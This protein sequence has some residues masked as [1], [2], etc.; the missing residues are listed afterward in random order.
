[1]GFVGHLPER[2]RDLPLEPPAEALRGPQ[3]QGVVPGTSARCSEVNR[4]PVGISSRSIEWKELGAIGLNLRNGGIPLDRLRQVVPAR[5]C[6][7]CDQHEIRQDFPFKIDMARQHAWLA[8]VII[9]GAGSSV[10]SIPV[11]W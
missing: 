11:K 7:T 4:T 1:L 6:E 3:L 5:A 2:I 10:G 8:D 9:D